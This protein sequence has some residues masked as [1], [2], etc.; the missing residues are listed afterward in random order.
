MSMLKSTRL[1]ISPEGVM[2]QMHLEGQNL[3][4]LQ[5]IVLAGQKVMFDEKTHDLMT[6][7]LQGPGPMSEKLG[8]GIAG[9]LGILWGESK[10]ALNPKLLIPAGLVLMAHAAQFLRDAGEKVED[11][12]ITAGMSVMI[13]KVLERAG[14]D[15]AKV[16]QM[17]AKQGAPA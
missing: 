11:R 3:E 5:R 6:K 7:Q 13:G 12:D 1:D 4:Q 8:V 2:R 16:A 14:L 9:L 17:G 10:G 15:P